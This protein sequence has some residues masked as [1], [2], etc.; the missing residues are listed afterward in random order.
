M[1]RIE[2]KVPSIDDYKSLP[3]RE[4][5]VAVGDM[6]QKDQALVALAAGHDTIEVTSPAPGVIKSLLVKVGD[7]VGEDTP[8]VLLEVAGGNG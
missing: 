8:V 1:A 3:V 2:V 7:L 6:V 5:L 4:L